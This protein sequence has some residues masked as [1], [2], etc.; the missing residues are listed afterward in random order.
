MHESGFIWDL[1][2]L[3]RRYFGSELNYKTTTM[4]IPHLGCKI[5]TNVDKY[6]VI[7]LVLLFL[8]VQNYKNIDF[9]RYNGCLLV[10]TTKCIL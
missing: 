1:N 4:R 10:I 9:Y 7:K 2:G 3:I 8:C 5:N 6:C